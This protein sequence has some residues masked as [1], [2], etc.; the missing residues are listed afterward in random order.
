MASAARGA[1]AG[2]V[3]T[4]VMTAVMT[5]VRGT[6]PWAGLPPRDVAMRIADEVSAHPED[7]SEDARRV[8]SAVAHFAYGTTAGVVYGLLTRDGAR[9]PLLSGTAF[10]LALWAFS[11]MG[12]LPA[13]GIRRPASQQPTDLEALMVAS[14]LVYG[15]TVGMACHMAIGNTED[16]EHKSGA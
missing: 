7:W 4:G 2:L 5:A 8:T 15:A 10:G 14:H 13:A 16:A 6:P 12:W 1:A 3:A 11:Y 9:H